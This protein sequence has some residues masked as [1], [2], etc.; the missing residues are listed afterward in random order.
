MME[1]S[2][3]AVCDGGKDQCQATLE[4]LFEY[5]E[6]RKPLSVQRSSIIGVVERELATCVGDACLIP[7]GKNLCD[8][9]SS[10]KKVMFHLQRYS[11][12]WKT[13]IDVTS[14]EDVQDGDKLTAVPVFATAP[15]EVRTKI[16]ENHVLCT[17]TLKPM[18]IDRM[19]EAELGLRGSSSLLVS[20][21][22]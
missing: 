15:S 7:P 16:A 4:V 22:R 8:V 10:S 12:K 17:L 2:H 9:P 19:G 3:G 13:Y 11:Q 6:S 14:E 5:K 18:N 20:A 1:S 21:F